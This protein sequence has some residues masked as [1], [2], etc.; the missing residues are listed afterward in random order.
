WTFMADATVRSAI[1][2]A[3]IERD[4]EPRIAAFFGDARANAYAV[5]ALTGTL[6]WKTTVE[7]FPAARITGSPVFHEG[8]IYVPVSSSEEGIGSAPEYECCK[9]RGSITALDA[10][11]GARIWKTYTIAEE[12]KPFR[13][14]AIGTQLFG[15]SGA[16][17]W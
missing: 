16:P 5:D 9:F 1:S 8:R 17:I 4:G 11:T 12:P 6:L 13:K 2:I 14:N 15:P 10:A 3:R 7:P